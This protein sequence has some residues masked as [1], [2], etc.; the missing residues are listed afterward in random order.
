[1]EIRNIKHKGLKRFIER[2]DARQLPSQYVERIRDLLTAVVAMDEIDEFLRIPRGNP[3]LLTG[4]RKGTYAIT[5]HANWRITFGH[6]P[7]SNEITD[8]DY[9]DYH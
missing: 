6:D 4:D 8:L 1:M 2:N 9:E 5:V 3:H 7:E